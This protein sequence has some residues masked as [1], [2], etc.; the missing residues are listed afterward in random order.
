MSG[1]R[2]QA[3]NQGFDRAGSGLHAAGGTIGDDRNYPGGDRAV[4][5]YLSFLLL[6]GLAL[7]LMAAG[8]ASAE[9][10]KILKKAEKEAEK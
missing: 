9:L 4:M 6:A 7:A 2:T 10:E 3:E 1:C 8:N 5:R